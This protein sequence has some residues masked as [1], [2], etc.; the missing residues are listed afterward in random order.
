[1][2]NQTK[3][4]IEILFNISARTDE[5]DDAA[6]YLGEIADSEAL[7]ALI[8]Y[9]TENYEIPYDNPNDKAMLRS[10]CG[11][12]IAQIWLKN[13]VFN[14]NVFNSLAKEAQREIYGAFQVIRPDLLKL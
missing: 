3:L 7:K 12:S 2:T 1:M 8:K 10:T 14:Q 11:E 13:G 9:A 5:R 4:L 6:I